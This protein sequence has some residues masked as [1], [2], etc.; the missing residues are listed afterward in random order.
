MRPSSSVVLR[1]LLPFSFLLFALLF[2]WPLTLWPNAIP[3]NP[4]A[5]VTDLL[6]TH[7]PNAEYIRASLQRYGQ[8][9]L[10]NTH[11]MSGQP[12]A[13]DPLAGLWYPPNWLLL[14]PG[15]P[16]PI[17]FNVLFVLHLA[18]AGYGLFGFLRAEGLSVGAALVGGVAFA[19]TP[20]LI[21]HLAAGHVSLLF[22][23]AWTPWLLRALQ[24]VVKTGGFKSG[25][26]A[27]ACLALIFVADVRWAFY[28][29]ALGGAWWL[30][31][32]PPFAPRQPV[33]LQ[34]RAALAFALLFLLLCA[35]LALPLAEFLLHSGREA[36]T[37]AEA[38]EFSLPPSY[39]LGLFILDPYG[40]HEY[41]T[42]LGL[43]TL[44]LALLGLRRATAFWWLLALVAAAFAL[45]THFI[46]FPF[47][48]KLIPGLSFLRV[49][50]RAWFL[51][52]LAATTLAAHGV[53][54]LITSP[55]LPSRSIPLGHPHTAFV[56]LLIVSLDLLR[57]SSALLVARPLPALTPATAWLTAQPGLFRVYSPRYNLPQ[58][59]TL[60]HADGV[61]PLYLEAYADFMAR[62]SGI[63]RAGYSVV[64][65]TFIED[66]A[67]A[68]TA[69]TLPDAR[70]LGLLNVRFL[71]T[72]FPLQTPGFELK[73][74]FESLYVYENTRA[75]PRAWTSTGEAEVQL[76]SP[77][78]IVISASG[79]GQLI[80]SE[81]MYPGWQASVDGQR[82]SIETV[83]SVLRGVPLP[84]GPHTIAFEFHPRWVYI[85]AA[86]TAFGLLI[87][88]G[89]WRWAK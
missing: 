74:T 50:S 6:V 53:Q 43:P 14:I 51:V 19:G 3:F 84:A 46:V 48:F 60:Q 38:G 1:R 31:H 37:L 25:A 13:A 77:N 8:L 47:F 40:F 27:G 33:G 28:A 79:P 20:K 24:R 18:W 63:P 30:V 5:D 80:L 57:V 26:L 11:I 82:A 44:F 49:P 87:L 23:I 17:V 86:L 10:W 89:L 68:I 61:D 41:L 16:L 54:R 56:L 71:V 34:A 2:L 81:I 7:L 65:P 22:A 78:R 75:R 12:L 21:A 70:A 69:S 85:G 64:V 35:G 73:Q 67:E 59:D 58:P 29:G 4:R 39:L 15:L 83:E 32:L 55:K 52:A 72:E 9:P 42:Y 76:W 66:D 45:G 62:A 88:I 36:L